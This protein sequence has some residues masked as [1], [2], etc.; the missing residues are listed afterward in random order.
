MDAAGVKGTDGNGLLDVV[1][2]TDYCYLKNLPVKS[3][4]RGCSRYLIPFTD[5]D[6]FPDLYLS[7]CFYTP[8]MDERLFVA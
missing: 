7:L 1:D 5:E 2:I 6:Y 8:E 3:Q 4:E